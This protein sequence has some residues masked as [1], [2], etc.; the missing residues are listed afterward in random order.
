MVGKAMSEGK[1]T[2]LR[3]LLGTRVRLVCLLLSSCASDEQSLRLCG[4]RRNASPHFHF[5]LTYGRH[6]HRLAAL[7]VAVLPLLRLA[8]DLGEGTAAAA[9]VRR[10]SWRR[11][12]GLP[13]TPRV[14]WPTVPES[15]FRVFNRATSLVRAWWG[16]WR[17]NLMGAEGSGRHTPI[18]VRDSWV[19]GGVRK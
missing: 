3:L 12:S 11:P 2:H 16:G 4:G 14:C 1:E 6:L 13:A 8:A 10:C 15:V 5:T 7:L 19:V 17:G 18:V 9:E